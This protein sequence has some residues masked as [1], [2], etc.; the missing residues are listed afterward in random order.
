[1]Q[2]CNFCTDVVLYKP[3]LLNLLLFLISSF[4]K[5]LATVYESQKLPLNLER[6]VFVLKQLVSAFI[7]CALA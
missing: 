7:L 1:M 2:F 4:S 3:K 6:I 5:E